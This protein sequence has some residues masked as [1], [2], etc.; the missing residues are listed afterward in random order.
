MKI[1]LPILLFVIVANIG[2]V[3]GQETFIAEKINTIKIKNGGVYFLKTINYDTVSAD[4]EHRHSTVN[5]VEVLVYD[6]NELDVKTDISNLT[7][8]E[9]VKLL[10][11]RKLDKITHDGYFSGIDSVTLVSDATALLSAVN[12]HDTKFFLTLDLGKTVIRSQLFPYK[13]YFPNPFAVGFLFWFIAIM[14]HLSDYR[15]DKMST[16]RNGDSTRDMKWVKF[17]MTLGSL[18]IMTCVAAIIKFWSGLVLNLI[19]CFLIY[20]RLKRENIVN[21]YKNG[22]IFFF[23]ELFVM[24]SFIFLLTHLTIGYTPIEVWGFIPVLF[25]LLFFMARRFSEE[26]VIRIIPGVEKQGGGISSKKS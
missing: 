4:F 18:I 22:E 24:F 14:L 26:P 2:S 19:I 3:F 9:L 15:R 6:D 20:T 11:E 13:L 7:K 12:K 1:N 21:K 23:L 25:G 5:T 10:R 16:E 8:S 17:F